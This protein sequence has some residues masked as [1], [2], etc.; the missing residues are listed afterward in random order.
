MKKLFSLFLVLAICAAL[1]ACGTP[2][3]NQPSGESQPD[4]SSVSPSGAQTTDNSESS[5]EKKPSPPSEPFDPYGTWV[6][7]GNSNLT[8]TL[9]EDGTA[10]YHD[11]E[12]WLIPY[13]HYIDDNVQITWVYH[14]TEQQIVVTYTDPDGTWSSEED[15]L[16]ILGDHGYYMIDGGEHDHSFIRTEH[17][18]DAH[19]RFLDPYNYNRDS[20]PDEV[21]LGQAYPLADWSDVGTIVVTDAHLIEF[22]Y[23]DRNCIGIRFHF[24]LNTTEEI[25]SLSDFF[26][27]YTMLSADTGYSSNKLTPY[28]LSGNEITSLP[29]GSTIEGYCEVPVCLAN[30]GG[31]HLL[32]WFGGPNAKVAINR[33]F[34]FVVPSDTIDYK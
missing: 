34:C 4:G 10:V 3:A 30:G 2:S 15:T 12:E 24:T 33:T 9:N 20:F 23:G 31:N 1:C 18:E 28:D 27:Y 32:R 6:W 16:T 14:E 8:L 5:P 26:E 19:S 17:F 29:A 22:S 11:P 13:N 25:Y 21:V 7:E